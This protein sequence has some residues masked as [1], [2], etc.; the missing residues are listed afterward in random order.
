MKN[1]VKAI[2]LIFMLIIS[3]SMISA[4]LNVALADHGSNI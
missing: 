3:V 4:A 2:I 1:S